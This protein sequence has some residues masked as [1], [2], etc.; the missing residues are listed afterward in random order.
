ME[1][2]YFNEDKSSVRLAFLL[3]AL[4]LFLPLGAGD[5]LG[6]VLGVKVWSDPA[7]ALLASSKHYSHLAGVVSL[8]ATFAF[9]TVILVWERR[10]HPENKGAFL[11]ALWIVMSLTMLGW[12]LG[13]NGF[14]AAT[15]N[16]RSKLG[17]S[18]SL[19][20]TGEAGYLVAL[21]FGLILGNFF[22]PVARFLSQAARTEWFIKTAIV[23]VGAGVALKALEQ[24]QLAGTVFFR[25]LAAIVEAYLVYWS[26]VYLIARKG[27]GFSR[28]WAAPLAS[29]ISICGVSAAIA[30]G[31]AIRARPVVAILVSS[32]VVVFSV[33]ELLVL[34][35]LAQAIVP[36]E[37]MV[38]AAWM[39]LA[40]KTDGAAI[41]SGAITEA[42]FQANGGFQKGWMLMTTTTVKIFIDLFIGV[43]CFVLAC[44]WVY[45]LDRK[46]GVRVSP[47][48][49]WDRFPKFVIGYFVAFALFLLLGTLLVE[50]KDALKEASAHLDAFRK[51]FFALAFFSIGISADFRRLWREGLG[52]LVAV[53][54]VCLFGFVI[55]IGLGISWLF[56]HGVMPPSGP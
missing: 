11:A 53:Y 52:R 10:R 55:W 19:G 34:P 9:L 36:N 33:V 2:I 13:H 8:L 46:P 49:I 39:G 31:A 54:V 47:R 4:A 32:L 25:G 7:K 37:P 50:K 27:F 24:Y 20:L 15:P 29:G 43:W 14:I 16:E 44:V 38:A 6:W 40:V 56:F 45:W 26:L 42:L 30:T 35:F 12:V 28:E 51:Y 23:L 22:Q 3:I 1:K 41:A 48:E 5:L 17:I 21:A 18:W